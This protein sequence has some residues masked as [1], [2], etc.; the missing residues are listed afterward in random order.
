MRQVQYNGEVAY[1]IQIV[2][3]KVILEYVARQYPL[4]ELLYEIMMGVALPDLLHIRP[5]QQI[6]EKPSSSCG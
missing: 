5:S 4:S 3:N 2:L 1:K 6:L